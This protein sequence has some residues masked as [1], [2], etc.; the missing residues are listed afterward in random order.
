[1]PRLPRSAQVASEVQGW[2]V[3]PFSRPIDQ[4]YVGLA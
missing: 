2:T 4:M 1:M 3:T